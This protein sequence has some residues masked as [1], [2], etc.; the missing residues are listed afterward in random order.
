MN[1]QRPKGTGGGLKRKFSAK[2]LTV[3]PK[4]VN[5][6]ERTYGDAIQATEKGEIPP[7]E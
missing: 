7:K 3:P 4:P 5:L 6:M 2:V 1:L